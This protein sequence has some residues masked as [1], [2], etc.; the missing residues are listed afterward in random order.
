[1]KLR[2]YIKILFIVFFSFVGFVSTYGQRKRKS[3]ET[4]RKEIVIDSAKFETAVVSN[5]PIVPFVDTLFIVYGDVGVVTARQRAEK[6][7]ENIRSLAEDFL[8]N[9]DSLKIRIDDMGNYLITYLDKTIIGIT[10]QQ[11]KSLNM[12]KDEIAKE[13]LLSITTA[14]EKEQSQ[15]SWE[16]IAHQIGLSLLILLIIYVCIRLTFYI[17][18]WLFNWALKQQKRTF[19]SLY[20]FIDADRQISLGIIVLKF[21]RLLLIVFILYICL[22]T[23]FR[24]FPETKGFSDTLLRYIIDPI[25]SAYHAFLNF[26]PDLFSIIVIIVIFQLIIKM[27]KAVAEKIKE[28]ALTLSGF[29]PDWAMPTFNIVRVILYIFM[30]ILIFPHLPGS[31]S[32]AFQGV[33]VFLGIL[34]SLGSTSLIGNIVSGIV[35]TYMRPFKVGDRIKMGEFMGNVIEKTPLVTRLKTPKN[36][37]IT[38]PNG[39]IM[40]AQTVNYTNSAREYGLILYSTVTVGYDIPWRKVH[41]L[42]IEAGTKTNHVMQKP[43][44]FILQTALNDF[45][46]EYQINVYTRDAN[47]MSNIYSD[48]NMNIQD[49]FNREGIELLSPHYNAHRDGSDVVMPKEYVKTGFARY[50][51][52][53][54]KIDCSGKE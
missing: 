1:M 7:N 34:F 41:T 54:V 3:A 39:N 24:L 25:K 29:F 45:Y 48:L 27:I 30:F 16:F 46:V 11:A 22:L 5:A 44:P 42:L 38:I 21:I 26:I 36:E 53:S 19:K 23:F 10:D 28:G 40:T 18:N 14:I 32:P 47:R 33:S 17:F 20:K 50:S 43:K 12:T 51:P 8:F 2:F 15:G 4:L 37:I 31:N 52:F 13:Y 9:A 49:I 35:I 6:I